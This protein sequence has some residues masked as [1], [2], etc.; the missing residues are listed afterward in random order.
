MGFIDSLTPKNTKEVEP[1]V[2]IQ[3]A[4]GGHRQ[5]YPV[6]WN[7]KINWKNFIVGGSY[8][9]LL[10]FFIL[11]F[12]VFAYLNDVREYKKF[13]EDV[14]ANI[15][16][17]CEGIKE[18]GECTEELEQKGLCIREIGDINWSEVNIKEDGKATN[19]L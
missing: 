11:L 18:L 16:S 3:R 1:S 7:G 4:Y 8:R 12:I 17:Y 19:P 14:H 5:I 10:W 15:F 9:H 2:F 13:Y 6:A